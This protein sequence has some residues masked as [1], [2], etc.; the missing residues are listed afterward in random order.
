[1][2]VAPNGPHEP[3]ARNARTAE[4]A[5]ADAEDP[6]EAEYG[7][8]EPAPEAPIAAP[9][10]VQVA[11]YKAES[12]AAE[13]AASLSTRGL[14]AQS[15]P[16]PAGAAWHVVRLGP[17]KSR[18]DAEKERFK[19]KLH[20]RIKA[21]VMPRSNG[22][23]HLQVGSFAARSEAEPV[24][25]RLSAQGHIVKISRIKMGDH[26]WHCVR[27]GPFDTAEEAADYQELVKGISPS[28]S[29]VIP[30]GPPKR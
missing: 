5:Q 16:D 26:R 29:V 9:Y 2:P 22:K 27:I 24:A 18:G 19:L 28:E 12:D 4:S 11:S 8:A 1:V 10:Y 17:F 21:F 15:S 14:S 23:Y 13:Y 7:R 25:E 6:S 20:E 3:A 30:Y